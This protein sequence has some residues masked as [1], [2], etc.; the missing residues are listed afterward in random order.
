MVLWTTVKLLVFTFPAASVAMRLKLFTPAVRGTFCSHTL[1]PR[2]TTP[3][4]VCAEPS[5]S[6]YSKATAAVSSSVPA[7]MVT[8][9]PL[10]WM[11]SC[12]QTKVREGGV[13]VA[14]GVK[15]ISEVRQRHLPAE[16]TARIEIQLVPNASARSTHWNQLVVW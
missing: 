7:W 4:M 15:H 11:L 13:A 8:V 1:P 14:I 5:L 10:T 16:S 3:L 9:S 12:G 6:V 2:S